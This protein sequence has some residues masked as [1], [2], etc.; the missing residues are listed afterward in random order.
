M[1]DIAEHYDEFDLEDAIER[2][3]ARADFANKRKLESARERLDGEELY[4]YAALNCQNTPAKLD[5]LAHNLGCSVDTVKEIKNSAD[6]TMGEAVNADTADIPEGYRALSLRDVMTRL[7]KTRTLTKKPA[8]FFKVDETLTPAIPSKLKTVEIKPSFIDGKPTCT[9]T[10]DLGSM[11]L[12]ASDF[13]VL[14]ACTPGTYT[15]RSAIAREALPHLKDGESTV[16]NAISRIKLAFDIA[17][18]NSDHLFKS[19]RGSGVWIADN[20]IVSNLHA[21]P[22]IKKSEAAAPVSKAV[23]TKPAP[24]TAAAKK[25]APKAELK[26]ALTSQPMRP[27]L[28]SMSHPAIKQPTARP[29]PARP[30]GDMKDA[31]R[32][33]QSNDRPVLKATH[34]Y[35][36]FSVQEFDALPNKRF[37]ID[38]QET[39][40][41]PNCVKIL[42]ALKAHDQALS[43][44]H[45]GRET[46]LNE[47]QVKLYFDLL[48]SEVKKVMK[49]KGAHF[50]SKPG[51]GLYRFFP[52]NRTAS[53]ASAVPK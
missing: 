41:D 3:E 32:H 22:A 25:P 24:K 7:L 26:A 5:H 6:V 16:S 9:I 39:F 47:A 11:Q 30:A 13:Q 46:Q 33:I 40:L 18:G 19:T 10:G 50:L 45:I 38:W 14:K 17:I 12:S 36:W 21:A 42:N 15:K 27:A 2:I 52:K 34:D 31:A 53:A 37:C 8:A 29:V 49:Q 43:A 44:V 1:S 23:K 28:A 51:T 48:V 20:I 35:G 4:V